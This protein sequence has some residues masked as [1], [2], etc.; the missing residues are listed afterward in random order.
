MVM[1]PIPNSVSTSFTASNL[2]GCT[3][4]STFVIIFV[5][6]SCKSDSNP[7]CI[8]AAPYTIGPF[9]GITPLPEILLASGLP[10][11]RVAAGQLDS[12]N[13]RS[14]IFRIHDNGSSI[15]LLNYLKG[16]PETWMSLYFAL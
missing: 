15:D 4:A 1:P 14:P 2:D 13:Q 12:A 5:S 6:S 11:T 9:Y 8:L 10:L 16:N 7:C 3:I